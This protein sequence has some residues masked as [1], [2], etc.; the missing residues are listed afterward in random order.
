MFDNVFDYKN[1][2]SKKE[3]KENMTLLIKNGR[4][5]DPAQGIDDKYDIYVDEGVVSKVEKH[6]ED[7]ADDVIDASGLIVAP[8]LIDIHVHL[9]EPGYEHKETLKSGSF[10]AAKGG[11]TTVCSMPDTLPVIDSVEMLENFYDRLRKDAIVN[12]LPVSS[13]TMGQG[14]E[15]LVDIE[16]M[17]GHGAVAISEDP[18]TVNNAA[19]FRKAMILAASSNIPVMT[20]CEDVTL[21]GRGVINDGPKS[22]EMN[23][24]GISN[25][26]EEVMVARDI[27][28]AKDTGVSL[29]ICDCSTAS[30]VKMIKIAKENDIKVS[31]EV[32]PHHFTLCDEDIVADDSNFKVNPPLRSRKD[33]EALREGLKDGTIDV[34][35]TDHSPHHPS[36]KTSSI[37]MSPFG[38]V[39]LET[40]LSVSIS[41]LV[42]KGVLTLSQLI[43][44]MSTNPAKIVG[45]DRGSLKV[46]MAADITIF[47]PNASYVIESDNFVSMG[48]NTPFEGKKVKGIVRYTIVGG[49]TVYENN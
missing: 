27:I 38:V 41:E 5:V 2:G 33:V 6:I 3:R 46:G 18:Y 21:A 7:V 40:S 32:S 23:V 45:I 8:G 37:K 48:K 20:H 17:A 36:E 9:R 35:A 24:M 29:H 12:V 31:A 16:S 47:D 13:V 28:L 25:S 42:D 4:L 22:M 1:M 11:F 14:G 44:K 19:L 15:Y 49:Y 26:T 39:G 30:S 10:A 34:I 43:E